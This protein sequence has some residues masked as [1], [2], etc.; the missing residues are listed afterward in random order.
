MAY[1]FQHP[2]TSIKGLSALIGNNRLEARP[3]SREFNRSLRAEIRDPVWMLARQWQMKEFKAEDRGSPAYAEVDM[4]Q[5]AVN[6]LT[7][8]DKVPV[9]YDRKQRPLEAAV[10]AQPVPVGKGLR[11]QMGQHWRQLLRTL[12]LTEFEAYAAL[13]N[14]NFPLPSTPLSQDLDVKVAYAQERTT[15]ELHELLELAGNRA[16]DGYALYVALLNN[17]SGQLDPIVSNP[18]AFESAIITLP[19]Y[20]RLIDLSILKTVPGLN[21]NDEGMIEKLNK[22]S[23]QYVLTMYRLYFGST[24]VSGWSVKDMAYKF[25]L[26]TEPGAKGPVTLASAG[27]NGGDL[28]WYAVDQKP[29]TNPTGP[30]TV[31]PSVVM[32][33]LP[34]EIQF[35]GSPNARWWEFEDRRVDF[36]ALTGDPSDFGRMLLQEFMFLYQNDWFSLP[37][38]VQVGM[39]CKI[40]SLKVTD[41]F[42]TSYHLQP[43]GAGQLPEPDNSNL[44]D[45]D[46][47]RWRLFDQTN[48][49]M[50]D[51]PPDL[52]IPPTVVAPLVGKPMEQVGFRRE[53]ATNLVWAV[54]QTISN[55]FVR[56]MDGH[57]AAAKVS[58]Y[59]RPDAQPNS[60]PGKARYLYQLASLVAENW[61]PFVAGKDING[62][63]HLEQARIKRQDSATSH[64]GYIEPRTSLLQLLPDKPYQVHEHE[65]PPAGMRIDSTFR[66]A[67]WLDGRT[68]LWFGRS[69]GSAPEGGSSGLTFDQLIIQN[70]E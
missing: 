21:L 46:A 40:N 51:S 29:S 26:L 66:R 39:Y 20:K 69:L 60:L 2:V 10:E 17:L 61:I 30:A 49:G 59:L 70:N 28:H 6:R 1:Q 27:H 25:S 36:G 62:V 19:L 32:R 58:E 16:I 5:L 14:L 47:G 55:G 23:Q 54:E 33:F 63:Y 38:E 56:G 43:S 24:T 67:R 8:P 52:F 35:P 34:T 13:F 44:I 9:N 31:T 64:E 37:F 18:K 3:R 22:L 41:V 4:A 12:P 45:N 57:G 65:I 68:I 50:A 11:L 42:G 48:I 15:A 7:F 53:E